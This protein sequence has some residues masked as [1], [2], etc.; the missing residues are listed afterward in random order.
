MELKD[1]VRA[2]I[3]EKAELP[4]S[5]TPDDTVYEAI[6]RMS[7][8]AVGALVVL[9][10]DQ[11]VGI[12]SERDYARKII[13]KGR[14][15]RDARVREIM[16]VDVVTAATTD[17]VDHCMKLLS[18]HHIRHLPIVEDDKIVGLINSDDLIKW[19]IRRQGETIEQL[20]HYI[21]GGYVH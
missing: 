3:D 17:T 6:A 5:I 12:I 16:T 19:I 7:E 14:T 13:L 8:L 15:S 10:N 9:E 1:S 4:P 20:E 18:K 2:V 11:I 21:T